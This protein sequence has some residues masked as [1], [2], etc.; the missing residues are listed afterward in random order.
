MKF[1]DL[2]LTC[3]HSEIIVNGAIFINT[4]D[5][6][7][8]IAETRMDAA[9]DIIYIHSEQAKTITISDCSPIHQGDQFTYTEYIEY[10]GD[11]I[12]D[13]IFSYLQSITQFKA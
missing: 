9:N 10:L 5:F 3:A 6:I 8:W 11:E 1:A 12:D 13:L 2:D 7:D 4:A